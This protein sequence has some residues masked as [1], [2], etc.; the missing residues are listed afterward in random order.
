MR[1]NT[2]N[3]TFS[4]RFVEEKSLIKG[5]TPVAA[6]ILVG[7]EPE[8]FSLRPQQS[9]PKERVNGNG[10]GKAAQP[11]RYGSF[12]EPVRDKSGIGYIQ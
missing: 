8:D 10:C 4:M 3:T 11:S 1:E 5:Y 2:E 9:A 6:L 7:V 12:Q